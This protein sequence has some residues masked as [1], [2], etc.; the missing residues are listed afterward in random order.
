MKAKTFLSEMLGLS[1]LVMKVMEKK[2]GKGS[3]DEKDLLKQARVLLEKVKDFFGAVRLSL[4]NGK[5]KGIVKARDQPC[6]ED[7]KE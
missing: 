2:R 3:K 1:K 6:L 5:V 7:I 4:V